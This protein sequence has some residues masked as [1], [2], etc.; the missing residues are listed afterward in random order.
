M[1]RQSQSRTGSKLALPLPGSVTS[2]VTSEK[3]R[4]LHWLMHL[5]HLEHCPHTVSTGFVYVSRMYAHRFHHWV[6]KISRRRAWQPTH[7]SILSLRIP[8]DRG[9]QW[10]TVQGLQ[11]VGH[12]RVTKHTQHT[13]IYTYMYMYHTCTDTCI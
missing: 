12:D 4:E 1:R 2:L 10:D 5:K 8:M 6:G 11:R 13:C 9:A 3:W 7:S